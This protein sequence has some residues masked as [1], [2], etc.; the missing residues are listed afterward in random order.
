[1][2][3][4]VIPTKARKEKVYRQI[5]EVNKQLKDIKVKPAVELLV[6]ENFSSELLDPRIIAEA[7]WLLKTEPADLGGNHNFCNSILAAN[8]EFVWVLGDDDELEDGTVSFMLDLVNKQENDC[9]IVNDF[10][11]GSATLIPSDQKK[12]FTSVKSLGPLIHISG[13][14]VRRET[15]LHLCHDSILYQSTFMPQL[16]YS[17][18][19]LKLN[20]LS[21]VDQKIY[22][23]KIS[24]KKV[25]TDLYFVSALVARGLDTLEIFIDH[26]ARKSWFRLV[27]RT[28]KNWLTPKGIIYELAKYFK[29][30]P[31][32]RG[33]FFRGS[34]RVSHFGFLRFV[35]YFVIGTII[36]SS[37]F[38]S[39]KYVE[40]YERL[41]GFSVKFRPTT[42]FHT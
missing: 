1:M 28:R 5:N 39:M 31:M 11:T 8:G 36:L 20:G 37:N 9:I 29:A 3:S 34:I 33:V 10:G 25:V 30:D 12:L 22:R 40:L 41:R 18:N 38:L 13:Y 15:F 27:R 6:V 7:N 2:I 35:F 19:C 14:I 32:Q 26:S 23:K 4:I 21:L 16:I 17:L 24:H 42:K